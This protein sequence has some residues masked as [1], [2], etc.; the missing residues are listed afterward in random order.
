MPEETKKP[1]K[2]QTSDVKEKKPPRKKV[3]FDAAALQKRL[4]LEEYRERK[5][6]LGLL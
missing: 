3:K 1:I 2:I 6:I 4:G 5:D